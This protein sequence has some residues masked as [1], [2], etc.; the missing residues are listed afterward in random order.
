MR[1]SPIL[2][3]PMYHLS[4]ELYQRLAHHATE[5]GAPLVPG[6][7]RRVVTACEETVHRL[8]TDRFYFARPARSLFREIRWC[9]PVSAHPAVLAIIAAYLD[10]L[11]ERF[12]DDPELVTQLTG[13]RLQCRA[14]A[15][16]GRPCGRRPRRNGYCPSHQHLAED[17]TAT[18]DYAFAA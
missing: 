2:E 18:H 15:R 5:Q 13:T 1:A 10:E 17:Q 12:A 8:A 4:R 7:A 3:P 16:K 6:A 11:A 14:W 9:F